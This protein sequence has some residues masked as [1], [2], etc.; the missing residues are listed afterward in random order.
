MSEH[1]Q[2]GQHPDADQL[3]AFADNALPAHERQ[4]TLAHVA[5]C[6]DCRSVVFLAQEA[7]FD[8]Q[9]TQESVT[10]VRP[11]RKPWFA[12]WALAWQ[13]AGLFA[14]LVVAVLYTHHLVLRGSTG[15]STSVASNQ[16]AP[17]ESAPGPQSSTQPA[18]PTNSARPA[19][20]RPSGNAAMDVPGE[21]KQPSPSSAVHGTTVQTLPLIG[22]LRSELSLLKKTPTPPP[23]GG[24]IARYSA[25]GNANGSV[26]TGFAGGVAGGQ[27]ADFNNVVGARGMTNATPA[28]PEVNASASALLTA[29]APAPAARTSTAP[30]GTPAQSPG[31]GAMAAQLAGRSNDM[32]TFSAQGVISDTP[33][34][35]RSASPAQFPLPSHLET[36][37]A[38]SNARLILAVDS[39]GTL[40]A[41]QDAGKHWKSISPQ[42][43][44][45][46]VRVNLA[47][48]VS[49]GAMEALPTAKM[50]I[51]K[52]LPPAAAAPQYSIQNAPQAKAGA[53]IAAL[54]GVVTDRTGAVVSNATVVATNAGTAQSITVRTDNSGHYV[55]KKLEPGVY[56]VSARSPGFSTQTLSGFEVAASQTV[57]KNIALEVGAASQTVTVQADNSSI[58]TE[59]TNRN[60]LIEDNEAA[61]SHAAVFELTTDS[62]EVWT[63]ADGR[64][65]KR[66]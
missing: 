35:Q 52:A 45:R 33:L 13:A 64:H 16:P 22:R 49:Y 32:A 50:Q 5:G 60:V 15:T 34:K 18:P 43:M 59:S 66:K 1:L 56:T 21:Q 11:V 58:Q 14:C 25:S 19:N 20:Q 53:G 54:T 47:P 12:G 62:G 63:S 57:V 4:E 44:G 29:P 39:A 28:R 17:V 3:S 51:S 10:P 46:A 41:S 6:E 26:A 37:S 8:D 38:I 48:T 36:V 55:V 9:A 61:D 30:L 31:S 2:P 40:F 27:S 7:A 23:I 42:W 24:T 65:W